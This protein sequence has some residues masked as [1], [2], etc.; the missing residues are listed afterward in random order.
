MSIKQRG[1]TNICLLVVR[2]R[3]KVVFL[4]KQKVPNCVEN[5]VGKGGFLYWLLLQHGCDCR[6]Q[7]PARVEAPWASVEELCFLPGKES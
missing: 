5:V 7:Y 4:K 1:G 3:S 6:S 2:A